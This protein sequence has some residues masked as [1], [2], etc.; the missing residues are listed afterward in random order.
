[1]SIDMFRVH[2]PRTI[3]APLLETLHSGQIGQGKK[4]DEFEV[5]LG[6]R[7]GMDVVTVNS[8]TA[9]LELALRLLDLKP[10]D[11]VIT[12]AMSCS[13][14]AL[15]IMHAGGTI[16]WADINPYTGLID[17]I[18]VGR[19]VSDRTRAVVPVEWG[20]TPCDYPAITAAIP[21]GTS[22][23]VDAA[24]AFGRDMSS[25]ADTLVDAF[26]FSFQAI[27]HIT[28]VDGGAIAFPFPPDGLI[29]RAKRLR[30]FGINRTEKRS[31]VRI[32][33]DILE[34][35]FKWHM[36]DVAATIG[37][38]QLKYIDVI[39]E[40]HRENARYFA[41]KL[42]SYFGQAIAYPDQSACWL[43]TIT[44]DDADTRNRFAAHMAEREI[45]VS[46][47]HGRLDKHTCF[48]GAKGGDYLPGTDDFGD[49]AICIP[50]H[51]AL[52]AI[53]LSQIVQ[54]CDEFAT[55]EMSHLAQAASRC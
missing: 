7:L 32:E 53:E 38:E 24:H 22:I 49:A 31:D 35:G 21:P 39:I 51:W 54:A 23:I 2:F 5:A 30:W 13:A 48:A 43:Y 3:D 17:P 50:V 45:A 40:H 47:A 26:C 11:E 46:R 29:D 19:K 42:H 44:L 10:G 28:T 6:A 16:V 36:N 20:G 18:D 8:G 34:A 9:A 15:A 55:I 4:V 41:T 27:K 1:M 37:I 12:T 25:Q 52:K 33:T 14:T